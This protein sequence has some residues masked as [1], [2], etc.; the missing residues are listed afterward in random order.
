MPLMG[1]TY[2]FA[3]EGH[4]WLRTALVDLERGCL[5]IRTSMLVPNQLCLFVRGGGV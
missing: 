2:M 1:P 5:F 4:V 3:S